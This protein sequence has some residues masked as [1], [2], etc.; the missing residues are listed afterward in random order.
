MR[1]REGHDVVVVGGGTAGA[2]AGIAAA[3]TGARTLLVEQYGS[4]GGVLTLGMSLKGVNDGEGVKALGGIG[5]EL[6][7]RA[8]ALGGTTVVSQHPRHGSIMGQDP[9]AMK[10]TLI[11]MVK[12]SGLHLLLHSFLADALVDRGSI[13]AVRVANKAGLEIIPAHCFVDCT[14]D[15]DLAAAAG[16]DVVHGREADGRL[17][18]VSAIFRVGG[19]DLDQ[20]WAY[21]EAHPEDGEAPPGYVGDAYSVAA[22]RSK[23]GVGMAGFKSLIRKARAAG[24]YHIPRDDMGFNPLV[25]RRE[26]TINI[27]RVHGIDGTDPDDLTRA[28]IETQLQIL[29]ALRF[30]R[31]YV[32]GFEACYVVSSPFQVGI[33]ETRRIRGSYVLTPDDVRAGRDFDDQVARGAY[34]LDIHD[35]GQAAASA[36][37]QVEGGGTDLSMVRRSYGIPA[38]CLI[39]RGVNNLVVAGRALSA[40]HEAAGSARGQPVC[41]ATGHAAG[42]IAALSARHKL[43]PSALDSAAIQSVLRQQK[44]VLRRD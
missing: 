41:M 14:G 12:E 6:I 39:A 13:Q 36:G 7:E 38:R 16:A 25:G 10:L 27:T 1:I 24:D 30:L 9:E 28:E 40:T 42:V 21:L 5:E 35:V 31:K 8:R 37:G 23:P 4:L 11:E 22:F 20:T 29:E 33:R 44:A 26:A 43:P 32:P 15:G 19:I 18:P 2:I 17:Q 3:R 34:P